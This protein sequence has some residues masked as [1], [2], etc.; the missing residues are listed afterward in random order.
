MGTSIATVD[1]LYSA[2]AQ[3]EAARCSRSHAPEGDPSPQARDRRERR[4]R[5][6]SSTAAL[7]RLGPE[8]AGY[9]ASPIADGFPVR[10]SPDALTT[11]TI[12]RSRRLSS[13]RSI[14]P[15]KFMCWRAL[16]AC[17]RRSTSA[18]STGVG[19]MCGPSGPLLK[20]QTGICWRDARWVST[21]ALASGTH[22]PA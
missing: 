14:R 5:C 17:T 9:L 21:N 3:G 2:P 15:P 16:A 7:H 19:G 12:R 6:V 22:F 8:F 1:A 13:L 18:G 10:A 20:S 4:L 11:R